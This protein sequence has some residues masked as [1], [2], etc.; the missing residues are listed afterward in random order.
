MKISLEWLKEY[1]DGDI[2]VSQVVD[3]LNR[4]GLMVEAIEEKGEDVLLDVETYAN[5][6]DTLG[7][8]GMAREVAAG[9]GLSLKEKTWPLAEFSQKTSEAV[10]V[11]IWDEDLCPRYCGIVVKGVKVGPSP[12]WLAKRIESMGLNPIN[13]IVDISNYVLFSTSHPIHAFDLDKIAG[14][15]IIIRRAKKGEKL[16]CLDGQDLALAPEMLVIAD[17]LKPV[18]LAGVIGGQDSAVTEKTKEVFIES[19]YFDPVSVRKTRKA[20]GIQTDAAYRFERGADIACP[21]QAALMAA[22]LLGQFGG[23]AAKDLAD[24]YPQPRKK[25]EIILRHRRVVDLLGVEV[26]ESFIKK[27]L[28]DLEFGVE[29]G[30]GGIWLVKVPFF[31]VD[32]DREIDL[33]EEIARFFGYKNIPSVLPPVKVAEPI[34]DKSKERISKLRPLLFHRGFNEVI[35][36]SFSDPETEKILGSGRQAV[37]IRNPVSAKSSLLRTSLLGGLME[38]LAWNKNRGLDAVHIFETGKVYSMEGSD[39]RERLTLG[40]LSA[41]PQDEPQWQQKPQEAGFFY[42][43]GACEAL[44][45]QLRY[46]P[47]SFEAESHPFFASGRSVALVYKEEKI[48]CLGR[49]NTGILDGFSVKPDVYAAEIN[50]ELLFGKQPQPFAYVPVVKLPSVSRDISLVVPRDVAYQEIKKTIEKL[51]LPILEEFQVVDLYSGESLPQD[52]VS[53]SFR[54]I[55]RHPQRTLLAEEVDKAEQQILNVLTKTFKVQLRKGGKID[56]GTGKN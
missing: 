17:E 15:K 55:Y 54:F 40:L 3:A 25:K 30:Q 7:H 4:I 32:I 20:A 34:P 14:A 24:V 56:N 16:L 39:C 43:K 13:N 23:R 10:D 28:T 44:M 26:E 45:E 9:L 52:T 27:T 19:A 49:V 2:S 37:E 31:R 36:F 1:L 35:T 18:A 46:E 48:G 51:P 47:F 22:S 12:A 50:L 6:P 29:T 53:L 38:T 41:G 5:R 33:I 42:I 11:Q 21:P 8:L